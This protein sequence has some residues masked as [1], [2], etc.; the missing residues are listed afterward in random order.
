MCTMNFFLDLLTLK[1]ISDF[2]ILFI[3]TL[4]F[5]LALNIMIR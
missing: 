2:N 4:T 5:W 3:S 1:K